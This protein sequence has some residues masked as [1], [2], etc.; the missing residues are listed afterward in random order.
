MDALT[1]ERS[2]RAAT[3]EDWPAIESLL[4]GAAL[5]LEGAHDCLSD[6]TVAVRDG[7]IIGCAALEGLTTPE[8]QRQERAGG[9]VLLR[10]VALRPSERGA[11]VGRR[12]VEHALGRAKQ[13]GASSAVLLTTTA[14]DFFAHLGFRRIDR[15]GVPANLLR[16]AEFKGAC[17]STAVIMVRALGDGPP[18]MGDEP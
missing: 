14:E 4:T 15:S 16:S 5:P 2:F 12:L 7:S 13:R 8:G 17:P 9:S 3:E 6:F 18:R 10:S 11:G 1:A